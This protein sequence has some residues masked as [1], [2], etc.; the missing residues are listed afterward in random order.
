[1]LLH[2]RAYQQSPPPPASSSPC[3]S[4]L[5]LL[6]YTPRSN[7]LG[8]VPQPNLHAAAPR[9]HLQSVREDRLVFLG[10]RKKAIPGITCP[11]ASAGTAAW[12]PRSPA[13]ASR[14]GGSSPACVAPWLRV[15]ISRVQNLRRNSATRC[16]CC[17]PAAA[18]S[19][20]AKQPPPSTH[21]YTIMLVPRTAAAHT[22]AQTH[23]LPAI[24]GE[25]VD[26]HDGL[27]QRLGVLRVLGHVH[28]EALRAQHLDRDAPGMGSDNK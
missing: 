26:A 17:S 2:P 28:A 11:A 10:G 22:E 1:M 16:K 5:K 27:P 19:L 3:C 13:P 20:P 9:Q 24:G 15:R 23:R 14:S 6:I 25:H 18:A 21:T 12:P 8:L 4:S 7:V